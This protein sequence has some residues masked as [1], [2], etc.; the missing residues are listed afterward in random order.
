MVFNIPG[1]HLGVDPAAFSYQ[2]RKLWIGSFDRDIMFLNKISNASTE[3]KNG[4][5]NKVCTNLNPK[6]WTQNDKSDSRIR[7]LTLQMTFGIN[8]NGFL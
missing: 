2:D 4:S 8:V 5:F 7:R 6:F 1:P 3:N